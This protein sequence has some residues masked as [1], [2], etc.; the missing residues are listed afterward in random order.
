MAAA[1]GLLLLGAGSCIQETLPTDYV[2][3]SQIEASESAL[4]GMVNGIYTTMVGYSNSDGGIETISYGGMR[5]MMEH[6]TTPM[7]CSGYTGFNTM[8]A[9]AYGAV[10]S[11]GS[12]RGIYPSYVY[13]GWIKTVNDIIGM[14]PDDTTEEVRRHYLGIAYAFRALYY[15]EL[16]QVMEYKTPGRAGDGYTYVKPENNLD[17]LGVPIVT[18]KTT[19][20]QAANNPRATVDEVYDLILGD[21]AKAESLLSDFNR[22]DKIEPNLACVYGSLA[23]VYTCLAS[24]TDIS[25]KYKDENAYWQKAAQYADQ[26]ISTSGCTPLTKE[27]WTDPSTGFNDR[28]SQNSWLWA[29]S[30]SDDNTT[31]STNGSFVFAMIM[32]NETNFSAYGW[33]VGRSI[34]RAMYEKLPD[35]DWRKLSWLD[36]TFFYKS[37]NQVDG[38]PYLVEKDADGQLINNKWQNED[39]SYSNDYDGFGPDKEQYRFA[40]SASFVRGQINPAM[41]FSGTPWNYVT[42]KFRPH[43]G[44]YNIYRT[45]GAT[46]YPIMRVEEM[47]FIKSEATLH[48]SGAS[49]AAAV[50]EPLIQTRDS[51]YRWTAN[52]S[53]EDFMK[54]LNFHKQIEFWGEGINYF[55]AK[56]LGLGLH[57]RY[58]GVNLTAYSYSQDVDGVYPGWTPPFNQAELNANPAVFN[59]NNP[60]TTPS[61]FY[62]DITNTYLIDNFGHPLAPDAYK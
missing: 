58:L 17:N 59:Y 27:Q 46:D 29:T 12:N 15:H 14:I 61:Q 49:A 35:T 13:Y 34:N 19:A 39:G 53:A 22:T 45:G 32:G 24:R 36:P 42:I 2:I 8:A 33:R 5:V 50:I 25:V 40:S 51:Q 48:T 60:Y 16:V 54:E 62:N 20:E 30:I 21:L 37:K 43:N 38:E 23:R 56:R 47:Y 28:N 52:A 44:V 57:R 55:D 9:W 41:G 3:D 11:I 4:E 1:A 7:M 18:E 6:A 10:S 31:A 26:A